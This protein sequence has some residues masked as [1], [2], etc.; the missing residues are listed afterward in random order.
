MGLFDFLKTKPSKVHELFIKMEANIFPKGEIDRNAV[1]NELLNILDN[2]ISRSEALDIFLKSV[3]ISYFS[4]NFDI[5]Q[6]RDHLMGYCLD[7]FS[8]NQLD[9]FYKYLLAIKAANRFSRKSPSEIW[10]EGDAYF[11]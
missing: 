6:L 8:E 4:E 9:R 3:F 11:W 10:R 2:K 7:R 1:V 5:D